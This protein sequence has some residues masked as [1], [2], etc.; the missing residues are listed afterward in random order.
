VK[1]TQ[2]ATGPRASNPTFLEPM[3]TLLDLPAVVMG[4]IARGLASKEILRL[5]LLVCKSLSVGGAL[6]A[7]FWSRALMDRLRRFRP[8]SLYYDGPAN[9]TNGELDE[10]TGRDRFPEQ[11]ELCDG[12]LAAALQAAGVNGVT[13]TGEWRTLLFHLRD[14][15]LSFHTA[16]HVVL[17]PDVAQLMANRSI[18]HYAHF[19]RALECWHCR[20]DAQRQCA[21]CGILLCIACCVR[22]SEDRPRPDKEGPYTGGGPRGPTVYTVTLPTFCPFVLCQVSCWHMASS[23]ILG[24]WYHLFRSHVCIVSVGLVNA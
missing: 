20:G 3:A 17:P 11:A 18:T 12:R 23:Q 14:L 19:V 16:A 6:E 24:S 10:L 9:D 15:S 2:T 5:H 7:G 21:G 1:L 13:W 22:C 8:V 4:R